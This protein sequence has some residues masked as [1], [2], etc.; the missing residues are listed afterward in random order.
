MIKLKMV[1]LHLHRGFDSHAGRVL[2]EEREPGPR[3]GPTY[4]TARDAHRYPPLRSILHTVNRTEPIPKTKSVR[5][6]D[7]GQF[8][9]GDRRQGESIGQESLRSASHQP[10]V[11]VNP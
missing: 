10:S 2:S 8:F 3:T 1:P 9:P 6:N 11:R 7:H 5:I 4:L